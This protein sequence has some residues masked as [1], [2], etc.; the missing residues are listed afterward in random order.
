MNDLSKYHQAFNY[1]D[2]QLL[3]Y[4][5][6]VRIMLNY[7]WKYIEDTLH[8]YYDGIIDHIFVE[9]KLEPCVNK[10]VYI[11]DNR[12]VINDQSSLISVFFDDPELFDKLPKL[13]DE[14]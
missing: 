11:F 9:F 1:D 12:I 14:R 8:D 13:L 2:I 5:K 4:D 3:L 10:Y 7:G 6:I